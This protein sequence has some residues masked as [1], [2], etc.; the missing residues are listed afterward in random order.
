MTVVYYSRGRSHS[1]CSVSAV[2]AA[3]KPVLPLQFFSRIWLFS[4]QAGLL[5]VLL[6]K[7]VII[8]DFKNEF[9]L[10]KS[11]TNALKNTLYFTQS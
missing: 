9:N 7:L 2:Y 6:E 1:H 8:V 5:V 11:Y 3:S 10:I 4:G